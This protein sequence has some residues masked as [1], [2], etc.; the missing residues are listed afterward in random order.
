MVH[1]LATAL[2][3]S[4]TL[5]SAHLD[6]LLVPKGGMAYYA[7][8]T[9]I[10]QWTIGNNHNGIDVHLSTDDRTWKTLAVDLAKTATKYS[11][12]L[13]AETWERARLRVCQK[14]G[15]AGCTD[16]DSVSNP[17]DGP[18]YVLVSGRFRIVPAPASLKL[19]A[20]PRAEGLLLPAAGRAV[21]RQG[22]RGFDLRGRLLEAPAHHPESPL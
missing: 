15:P 12:T 19:P 18:L 2:L 17:A 3:L 4:A 11:W 7:G 5:A 1:T 21:L 13:P 10:V 8:S 16:A 6:S 22:G 14:S 9:L 20:A